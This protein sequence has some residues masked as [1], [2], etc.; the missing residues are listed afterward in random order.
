MLG[1]NLLV[2]IAQ[3]D[4]AMAELQRHKS[5]LDLAEVLRSWEDNRC[6]EMEVAHCMRHI[7]GGHRMQVAV[8][9]S[10]MLLAVIRSHGGP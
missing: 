3:V 4:P 9:A 8:A 6:I 7:L 1:L 2:G 10:S 5:G